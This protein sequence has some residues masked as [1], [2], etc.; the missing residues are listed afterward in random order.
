MF[1]E[2][3]LLFSLFK[4]ER[5]WTLLVRVLKMKNDSPEIE[6]YRL[7]ENKYTISY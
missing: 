6:I 7:K 4:V 3:T 2:T 1:E 5:R